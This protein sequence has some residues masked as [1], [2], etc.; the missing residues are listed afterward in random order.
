MESLHISVVFPLE[1]GAG[2]PLKKE[3]FEESVG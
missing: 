3:E 2:E 1:R